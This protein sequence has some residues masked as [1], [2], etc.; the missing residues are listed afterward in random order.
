MDIRFTR[1]SD[2]TAEEYRYLE[3][4]DH[5]LDR[6]YADDLVALFRTTD[7]ATGYPVTPMRHALQTATRALRDRADDETVFAALFHDIADRASPINHASVGAEILRPFIGPRTHWILAHHAI[8]QGYYYWHHV[9]RNRDA[10]EQFRGQ[11]HFDACVEFCERWDSIS[12]DPRYDTMPLDEFM[13]LVRRVLDREPHALW[14]Q[15]EA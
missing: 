13:P 10:R 9:G 5:E 15:Q 2:G 1:L 6:G 4:L 3:A 8:F 12:F 11:P 7:R 14:R